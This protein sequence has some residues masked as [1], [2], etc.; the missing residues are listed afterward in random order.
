[1]ARSFRSDGSDGDRK[2]IPGVHPFSGQ[3]SSR[4]SD[5]VPA[6]AIP[7]VH[8][9]KPRRRWLIAALLALPVLAFADPAPAGLPELRRIERY[10]GDVAEA[11]VSLGATA[12]VVV[13]DGRLHSL[14]RLNDRLADLDRSILDLDRAV[15]VLEADAGDE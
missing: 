9:F 6:K 3:H 4:D 15:A 14:Q 5:P 2:I 12:Q 10:A 11:A 13:D 8:P 1:M 7:G